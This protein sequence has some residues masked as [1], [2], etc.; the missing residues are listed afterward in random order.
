[1]VWVFYGCFEVV[2]SC[3]FFL[4]LFKQKLPQVC[5][6]WV[7][8]GGGV[9]ATFAQCPKESSFFLGITSLRVQCCLVQCGAMWAGIK[10]WLHS[11]SILE[12]VYGWR[13]LWTVQTQS[14]TKLAQTTKWSDHLFFC[15]L[16]G[17]SAVGYFW[18]ITNCI[19]LMI[20]RSGLLAMMLWFAGVSGRWFQPG[21]TV[22][23]RN[24][25]YSEV[26]YSTVEY[27]KSVKGRLVNYTQ[28]ESQIATVAMYSHCFLYS[29]CSAGG[30]A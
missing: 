9:K 27:S 8:G 24:V 21:R 17:T 20:I 23:Y 30:D 15:S 19:C 7:R 3:T 4:N 2:F 10:A 26:H 28:A 22:Q 11:I 6:K 18:L 25:Q 13:K 12:T 1:M 14:Q 5:P 29:Q 16:V